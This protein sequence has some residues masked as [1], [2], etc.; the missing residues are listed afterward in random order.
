MRSRWHNCRIIITCLRSKGF[1]NYSHLPPLFWFHPSPTTT[2]SFRDG[3]NDEPGG[4]LVISLRNLTHSLPLPLLRHCA[5]DVLSI[6]LLVFRF[7]LPALAASSSLSLRHFSFSAR[8]CNGYTISASYRRLLTRENLWDKTPR[9]PAK[10]WTSEFHVA[11]YLSLLAGRPASVC[12][13]R[14]SRA[15]KKKKKKGRELI[16]AGTA[17]KRDGDGRKV[18]S[19]APVVTT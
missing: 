6:P 9:S 1:R 7:F 4:G 11:R 18:R 17:W 3:P 2:E 15:E 8:D 10:C 5:R 16:V 19:V 12:R 13:R 14:E